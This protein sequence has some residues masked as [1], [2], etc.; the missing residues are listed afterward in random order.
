MKNYDP[1]DI[2]I[3][4]KGVIITGYAEGTFCNVERNGDSYELSMG[5]G[6]SAT[7]VR[8]NDRSGMITI[9]LQAESPSNNVLSAAMLLDEQNGSGSGNIEVVNQN[10]GEAYASGDAWVKKPANA[11][12][13]DSASTR[14]WVIECANL[15]MLVNGALS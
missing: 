12:F 2:T 7:R 10:G 4:F 8:K 14:E 13:S 5:A 6:G 9:T 15:T 3:V 11:E 1:N